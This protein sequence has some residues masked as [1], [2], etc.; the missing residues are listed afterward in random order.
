MLYNGYAAGGPHDQVGNGANYLCAPKDPQYLDDTKVTVT[1]YLYG[2][3][4]LTNNQIFVGATN[5]HNVPCAVCHA[6]RRS[7]LVMIP[8]KTSCQEDWTREYYGY[9]MTTHF[10]CPQNM[11]YE[12]VDSLPDTIPGTQSDSK[13]ALFSFVTVVCN[14]GLPCG[15]YDASKAITCSVCTK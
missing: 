13:G 11:K 8:G 4:F 14:K 3:E 2:S 1:S 6:Q 9:L 10:N 15:P 5:L 7:S 12:C